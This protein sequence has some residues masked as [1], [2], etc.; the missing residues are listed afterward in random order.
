MHKSLCALAA[1]AM[2]ILSAPVWG[3]SPKTSVDAART[4]VKQGQ[5]DAALA[6]LQ[7]LL[8]HRP[9]P[10]DVVFLI[11]LAAIGASQKPGLSEK[12]RDSLVDAAI[13]ALHSMLVSRPGLVRVRLELARAFFLKGEDA[14]GAAAFRAGPC[15]Q[16]AGRGGAQRQPVPRRNPGAQALEHAR[17]CSTGPRQQYRRRLG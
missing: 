4:L 11:G 13:T 16:A 5:Y 17:R 8:A 12:S 15:R 6:I 1:A 10:A 7:P 14:L 3:Q 9:V 2:L